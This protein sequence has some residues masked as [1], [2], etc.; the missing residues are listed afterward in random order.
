MASLSMILRL[1]LVTLWENRLRSILTLVGM[2]FGNAAVIATLSSNEGAKVFIAKQLASLGNKLMT[3]ELQGAT[4]STTDLE[5]VYRYVDNIDFAARE[6][7]AGDG[8]IMYRR[9]A[10]G[11]R[12][13]GV[14]HDYF[15]VTNLVL[16]TGR[17]FLSEEL[18]AGEPVAI[19]GSNVRRA[20]FKDIPF[21]NEY[22]TLMVGSTPVML[23]VIGVTREKGGAAANLDS[24]IF[25][26]PA[27]AVKVTGA[28]S[29]RILVL[30]RDDN[31]SIG[32]KK[33]IM[34]LLGPKFGAAMRVAD[35]REAIER[36]KAIWGKQNLVGICLAAI[37]LLT[38]GVGIM[39]IMLLSIHQRQKEI[40]LRKAVGARNSEIATQF[41][42]ET[43]IICVLGGVVGILVGWGFGQQVAKMLGDWEASMSLVSVLVALGFSVMTGVLFG[44]TPAM[45]AAR[46]DPYDALRT[47]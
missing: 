24:S 10:T 23:R 32:V 2:V 34:A 38:G 7:V 11:V 3:V 4:V 12:I 16:D 28:S 47:G 37:S 9:S 31:Q 41:L 27:L 18:S 22:V 13:M 1:A 40:G 6:R 25:I 5:A 35:A 17:L 30:L 44:A 29:D 43:V 14:D 21:L 36:T 26:S 19:I 39:N 45:R 15:P 8:Q 46:I 20:L 42:L 33:Q